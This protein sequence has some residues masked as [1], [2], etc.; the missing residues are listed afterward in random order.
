[1][2]C[3]CSVATDNQHPQE[4]WKKHNNKAIRSRLKNHK[5]E[6]EPA[7]QA[8]W[9]GKDWKE[10]CLELVGNFQNQKTKKFIMA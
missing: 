4:D 1:M 7:S 5:S 9:L 3:H 6:P 10:C 8:T 2:L